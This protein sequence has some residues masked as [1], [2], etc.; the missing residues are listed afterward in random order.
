MLCTSGFMDDVILHI[1]GHMESR[2]Y[3]CSEWRRLFRR[4]QANAVAALYWLRRVL[5]EGGHKGRRPRG[6]TCIATNHFIV[7]T[8]VLLRFEIACNNIK[9][10]L[11]NFPRYSGYIL[12]DLGHFHWPNCS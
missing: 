9:P 3:R 2:H 10:T 1:M 7:I 11:A 6:E 8:G 12:R 5:D 4:A